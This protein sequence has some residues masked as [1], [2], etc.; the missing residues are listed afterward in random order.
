MNITR[1]VKSKIAPENK[2][3]TGKLSKIKKI[4]MIDRSSIFRQNQ[5]QSEIAQNNQRKMIRKKLP[6]LAQKVK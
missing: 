5:N 3:L 6:I 4:L 1:E 2:V